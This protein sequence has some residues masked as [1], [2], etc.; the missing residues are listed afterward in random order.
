LVARESWGD[1]PWD[2]AMRKTVWK[3]QQ[4]I[5]AREVFDNA[6]E[7]IIMSNAPFSNSARGILT[8]FGQM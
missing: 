3:K 7:Y 5:R 4:L 1:T 8:T 2:N 6:P